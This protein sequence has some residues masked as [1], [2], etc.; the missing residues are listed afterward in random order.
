MTIQKRDISQYIR[1][2]IV[3]MMISILTVPAFAQNQQRANEPGSISSKLPV[4]PQPLDDSDID[5]KPVPSPLKGRAQVQGRTQMQRR[6]QRTNYI[7]PHP[8][9][10][11]DHSLIYVAEPEP[12]EFKAQDIIEVIVDEK[13]STTSKSL[14]NRQKTANMKAEIKELIRLDDEK[15]LRSAAQDGPTIDTSLTARIQSI[16]QIN[17]S[18]GMQY[19]ISVLIESVLPNGNLVIAGRKEIVYNKEVWNYKVH[20]IIRKE[21]VSPNNTV[22]SS[23]IVNGGV[24]KNTK[25]KVHDSTKRSWGV[26]VLDKM[27]PF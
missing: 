19:R 22:L 8:Q 14:F 5:L 11:K 7:A 24:V 17:D 9:S 20:G 1:I 16:G 26:R 3:T 15:R 18:E 10:I 25:G 12:H 4:P 13:A 2:T 21:D 6:V 27:F 23:K